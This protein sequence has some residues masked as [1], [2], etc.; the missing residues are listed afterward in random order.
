MTTAPEPAPSASRGR[1]I[2]ARALL[3]VGVLLTVVSILSTYV[4]REA[5]DEDQFKQTSRALIESPAIQEQVSAVMVDALFSNVDVKAEL[6]GRLPTN[7]QPLAVP[8]AGISQG[9]ADT[10][11]QK[12]LA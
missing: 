7:L 11:A 3:V 9:F 6:E 12:L 10:A 5:L 4:K 1:I 8:L 2:A